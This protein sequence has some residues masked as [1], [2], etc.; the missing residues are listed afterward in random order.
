MI[1]A[2]DIYVYVNN[3]KTGLCFYVCVCTV[4]LVDYSYNSIKYQIYHLL[5]NREYKKDN[6][7]PPLI[8]P[9]PSTTR[10]H[11]SWVRH[12][13]PVFIKYD[14]CNITPNLKLQSHLLYLIYSSLYS[15]P[16]PLPFNIPLYIASLSP[17]LNSS[18]PSPQGQMKYFPFKLML[19]G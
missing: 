15:T 19:L 14:Q 17:L 18:I 8:P 2:L 16:S 5:P 11:M 9:P 12:C 7:L 3:L 13:V 10:L 4:Y 1:T 6:P